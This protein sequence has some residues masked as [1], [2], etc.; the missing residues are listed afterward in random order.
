MAADSDLSNIRIEIV[1]RT[2]AG[3]AYP[4]VPTL[5]KD[6]ARTTDLYGWTRQHSTS[7]RRPWRWPPRISA[8]TCVI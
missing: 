3:G 2:R 6:T 7:T 1:C 4:T 5:Y 8:G